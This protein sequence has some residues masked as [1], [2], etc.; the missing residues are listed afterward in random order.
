MKTPVII[1]LGGALA[2][3]AATWCKLMTGSVTDSV[4]RQA[5]VP[6][7]IVPPGARNI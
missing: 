6:V 5:D 1:G 2:A 4:L 3:S 7:M